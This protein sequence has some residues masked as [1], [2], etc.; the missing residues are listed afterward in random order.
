M[1]RSL[2]SFLVSGILQRLKKDIKYMFLFTGRRPV[3]C[4]KFQC[5]NVPQTSVSSG[6]LWTYY[7][8]RTGLNP[9]QINT[10]TFLIVWK[11]AI[12]TFSTFA[13]AKSEIS[14]FWNSLNVAKILKKKLLKASKAKEKVIEI[15]SNYT[16]LKVYIVKF[17]KMSWNFVKFCSVWLNTIKYC[18]IL[19]NTERFC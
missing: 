1:N 11:T 3:S 4:I 6:R 5:T 16:K 17:C 19:E 8:Q 9:N 13:I 7:W 15:Q 2:S 14:K 18:L 12:L 10:Q